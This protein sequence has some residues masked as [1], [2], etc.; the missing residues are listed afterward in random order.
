M[1]ITVTLILIY[2][3]K[4]YQIY[5]IQKRDWQNS[6]GKNGPN[7]QLNSFIISGDKELLAY[8]YGPI[9]FLLFVNL[10]LFASTARQLTCGIWKRDDVKST[11]EK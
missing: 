8:F 1:N 11:T 5:S 2:K 3:H 9:G 10:L 7:D 6:D 4:R